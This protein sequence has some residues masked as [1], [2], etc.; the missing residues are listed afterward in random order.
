MTTTTKIP[1]S[2]SHQNTQKPATHIDLPLTPQQIRGSMLSSSSQKKKNGLS[3]SLGY[4]NNLSSFHKLIHSSM[5]SSPAP[6]FLNLTTEANNP[7]HK[8]KEIISSSDPTINPLSRSTA[9]LFNKRPIFFFSFSI[10]AP[11]S[12]NSNSTTI[13]PPNN[14]NLTATSTTTSSHSHLSSLASAT[15]HNPNL[16]PP[17]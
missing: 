15:A 4:N 14:P 6:L 13:V 1:V 17:S 16:I 7:Y 12:S 10:L 8:K 9:H 2:L 11:T 5:P 3:S